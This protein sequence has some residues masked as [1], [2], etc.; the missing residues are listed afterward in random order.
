MLEENKQKTEVKDK[1]TK[2]LENFFIHELNE[3]IKIKKQSKLFK[4]TVDDEKARKLQ[5]IETGNEIRKEAVSDKID[6][7]E[8][9]LNTNDPELIKNTLKNI[10]I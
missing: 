6:K 2:V 9:A 7:L 1:K 4:N 10:D 5:M 3:R 8:K